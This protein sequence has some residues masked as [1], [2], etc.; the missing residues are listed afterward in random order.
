MSQAGII[1]VMGGG[2]GGSPIE[3]LTG[4]SGGAVPPTANN[5]NVLGDSSNVNNTLGITFI[6][7]PSSSALRGT[8]TN[9]ITGTATT[10]DGTT[11]VQVYSFPLGATPGVYQFTTNVVAFN[12]TDAIAAGY[13][14]YRTVRTTGAAGFLIDATIN[15]IGE[16]G[17]MIDVSVVNSIVGNNLILTV[18]GLAGKSIDFLALTTFIFIG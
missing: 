14:S 10:T 7:S 18:T 8:L 13:S 15:S 2:G 17:A 1:N 3:T 16:E 11:P 4:D 5:I 6:G 9:R 12:T